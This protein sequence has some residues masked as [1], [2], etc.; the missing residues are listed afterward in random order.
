[1][2]KHLNLTFIVCLAI[3]GSIF[4]MLQANDEQSAITISDPETADSPLRFV[5]NEG[6]WDEPIQYRVQL[7]GGNIFFEDNRLTYHL[8]QEPQIK[9]H[10]QDKPKAFGFWDQKV[11]HHVFRM[12]FQG[13]NPSP[14]LVAGKMYTEYHNYFLG[15]DP[16]KWAGGVPLYGLLT[17]KDIYP[18]IDI[19]FY[20][21]GDAM[22]Y[23]FIVHPGA[24]PSLIK[25][26][27]PGLDNIELKKQAIVLNNAVRKITEMPPVAYQTGNQMAKEVKC[28]YVL[29]DGI[30]SYQ[31]PK[32]YDSSQ[33]LVIDPTLVF[34][35]YSGSVSNNWGFTATYDED[36]NAYGG[37]IQRDATIGSGYPV[38]TGAF[39][40]SFAGGVSDVTISKFNEDGTNLIYSTFLGGP[41]GS[42]FLTEYHDQPHSMIVT[43]DNEL[44][45]FGRTNSPSFPTTTG[46]YDETANGSYDIF[47]TKFTDDGTGLVGSTLI[48]GSGSDGVNGAVDPSTFTNTKYNYGDDSRGEVILDG[49]GNIYIAGSTLSTN[50]PMVGNG[51]QT[52]NAGGQDG[53]IVKLNPTLTSVTWSSY[54]GGSDDDAAYTIKLDGAG[55]IFVAG[56]TESDNMPISNGVNTTYQGGNAD[57]YVVRINNSGTTL[58]NGTYLGTDDY[59]QVYLLDLDRLND[60]YVVGQTEGTYPTVDPPA[61]QVYSNNGAKQFITKLTNDLST[62]AYST[63][64]GSN[65]ANR[66]NISPTALLVDRCDN[67][68]VTGWGGSTNQHGSTSGMP[69]SSDG[70]STTDGSDFYTIVISRDAQQLVYGSYFHALNSSGTAGDHVDGGTS[71][72]DKNGIVY[73][74]VCAGCWGV[75][76]FTATPNAYSTTN[77]ATSPGNT[78]CNLLVFKLAFD[79]E[80]I[81]ADFDPLDEMGQAIVND[82]G[83]APFTATFDNLSQEG[84]SPGVVSYNWDFDDGGASSTDF[85]PTHTFETPGFYDV[86]LI[87]TDS[88]SCN[89]A[90]TVYKTIEVYPPPTVDA[91]EDVIGCLGDTVILTSQ[92]VGVAYQWSPVSLIVG[93]SNVPNPSVIVSPQ[94]NFILTLTDTNGCEGTDTVQTEVDTTF[95][96]IAR[97]DTTICIGETFSLGATTTSPPTFFSWT[98]SPQANISNPSIPNPIVTNLDTT[99]VFY[100]ISEDTLGCRSID[101][102]VIEVFEVLTLEDTFIC[103][104]SSIVLASSNGV[105]FVWTPDDGSLSSTTVASPL[106]SP[107]VTTTYSVTATSINGCI[108]NKSILV[109]VKPNPVATASGDQAICIG[110]TIQFEASGGLSYQWFPFSGIS[111][112]TSNTPLVYPSETTNYVLTVTD[113]FGCQDQAEVNVVVNPLPIVV[114][115]G[116]GTICEGESEPL[117]AEGAATYSWTPSGSLSDPTSANPIASPGETTTYMVTGVDQ[118]GCVDT[119]TVVLEVVPRP[120]TEILGVNFCEEESILLTATGGESYIW[121]TGETSESINVVPGAPAI[122]IATASV[123]GCEGIPDSVQVDDRFGYP[124]ANFDFTPGTG[125]A[126]VEITFTNTTSGAT[127]YL[128]KFG[129]GTV[130]RDE[131][132]ITIFPH[133]GTFDVTLIANT[134][135]NCMDTIVQRITIENV[136]LHAPTAFSPN[137]D[138]TNDLFFIGYNGIHTLTVKIFSRWGTKIYESDN[139]DFQW[140]G[141]YKAQGVPEGVYVYVIQGIGEN[142]LQYER[143]GTVTLIR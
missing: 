72:F 87:I 17:Y 68:Y 127:S 75:S 78:G 103:D 79:L 80:G 123:G 48:G 129:F 44:V 90:D 137:A 83:C 54:L 52:S 111:D 59:D 134:D 105:S 37:G 13:G 116:D 110:D 3:A 28:K 139:P 6:Q 25:I 27:Y 86:R 20:G 73:H 41:P 22:K 33:P 94:T 38:T 85:E 109:E 130:S 34:V 62:I 10:G 61:G 65:N 51:F 101:S 29:S 102:V 15:N 11:Q 91:G 7:N 98:S 107:L 19:R 23:D 4:W 55:N 46:A 106:A 5:K 115:T 63:N 12:E 104:G 135:E 118:N 69:I 125:F 8:L 56:G 70:N 138:G 126:P 57:G 16:T 142:E 120:I 1:M 76:P 9:G 30:V 92:T 136:T 88:T 14:E 53:C 132:P 74:A 89:I 93:A 119:A 60:I 47:V 122:Y 140:D 24:D 82:G 42:G 21:L 39:Q 112:P 133:A 81:Q 117:S 96:V 67:V 66:P 99:T 2:N 128:W 50:F 121:S 84:M 71:R 18:G 113:E 108:S 40:S 45:V 124:E 43:P 131:N 64:F 58:L 31:F 32:S 77:N 26:A 114:A 49:S 143:V 100:V 97:L 35:T 95:R 36:G 141:T